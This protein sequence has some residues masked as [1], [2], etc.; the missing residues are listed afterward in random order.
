MPTPSLFADF[1]A[2]QDQLRGIWRFKWTALIVSWGVAVVAWTVVFLIPNTYQASAQIF[3]DTGTTLSQATKGIS[4]NDNVN[5]QIE[6]VTSAILGT[7]Q[8][9]KVANQTNLMAGA[10]TPE[11]QQTVIE[12]LR[13]NISVTGSLTGRNRDSSAALF[14]ITYKDKNRIRALTV[15]NRLL[16]DFIEGSLLSKTQGS[17]QAEQFLTAQIEAYGRRLS[18][19]EQQ[20][21]NFKRRNIGL[22]PGEK[23]DFFTRLQDNNDKLTQLQESLYVAQRKR[24]ALAQELKAGQQFTAGSFG[25]PQ[26]RQGAAV[27]DTEQQ[28]AELRQKLDQLL[29]RYTDRYPTV[30][31]LKGTIKE[32]EA[33]QRKQ[34]A[35]AQKGNVGAASALGLTA[36]PVYQQLEEQYNAEEVQIA[37]L[38]QQISDR[39]KKIASLKAAVNTAPLV[40]AEYARLTRNYTVTKTQYDALLARLDS[41]RLGQQAASTGLV[42]FQVVNPP[43]APFTPVE[44]KRALLLIATFFLALGAGAGVAYL[45]QLMRPVFVSA[46]QLGAATGLTVLGEVS[47]AWAGEHR[48]ER[49]RGVVRY[50]CWTAALFVAA[51]A[52]LVLHGQIANLVMELRA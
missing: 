48:A 46:R 51:A 30:I 50:A 12:N 23:G 38:Q 41:T 1:V 11:Q 21:A 27:L 42:K 5:D 22:V 20:L 36:N 19:T 47:M 52:V 16:N 4:L 43:T 14:T 35:A 32:L 3:V 10:L 9:E 45:L 6:R 39:K 49:H 31:T 13:Q 17:Q 2:L 40:Q 18:A 37:S 25:A 44:P 15:V 34:M 33:R 7:P 28:I 26:G 24:E 29:L 8:L